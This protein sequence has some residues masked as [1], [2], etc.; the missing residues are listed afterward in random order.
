MEI[1]HR[2]VI[3]GGACLAITHAPP[4]LTRQPL[5]SIHARME[6]TQ[7]SVIAT[8]RWVVIGQVARNRARRRR[9]LDPPAYAGMTSWS[10]TNIDSNIKGR[11]PAFA[12]MTE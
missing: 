10:N 12:D 2:R 11:M 3:T 5:I 7:R 8:Q 4:I 1:T 6:I 9:R